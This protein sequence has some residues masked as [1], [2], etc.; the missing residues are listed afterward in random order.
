MR[1]LLTSLAACFVALL[2]AAPFDAA[3]AQQPP[4]LVGG[5]TAQRSGPG[6]FFDF[7]FGPRPVRPP[8]QQQQ[9]RNK[10]ARPRV[11]QPSEPPV[12][13]AE[14]TP[15]DEKARKIM[16]VGDFVAG[17]LAWGL[18]QTFADEP[19]IAVL[20][21]SNNASGLVRDDYYDW[22]KKLPAILNEQK[23]DVVIVVIG[24]NDRQ[25]LRS[26]KDR[27]AVHSDGWEKAYVNRITGLADTLK[28]FGRPFFWV[29]APPMGASS[30][31]RDMDYFN[32]LYKAA[33]TAAGGHYVDIW[34]GFTDDNGNY[35]SSG[36]DV[37]GQLR[38]LRN[39][40]GINFTRA[41]RLK[42]AFYVEREIRKQTGIGA[43]AVDLFASASQTT[44]I[45]IGP[46]G[47]K[48]LVG[49]VISL[50]DPLPGAS[51]TLVGGADSPDA[52]MAADTPQYKLIVEGAVQPPLPGR[53]DDFTWP[54]SRRASLTTVPTPASV[55][56]R[57]GPTPVPAVRPATS[58]N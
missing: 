35:T 2:L 44:Q 16:V 37:D 41:G 24:A 36:P 58:A 20:D 6:G 29:S 42:L 4:G 10:P 21:Q 49:P 43:G 56:A 52:T 18:D 47:V 57:T 8:A 22:N 31:S 53:A 7:L 32:G 14:V 46:D 38:A 39:S 40:D 33:V 28:V 25:Q 5:Q 13:V 26:G 30:A 15:K 17:G 27:L 12:A 48:R 51:R 19:K 50:S 34:N 9:Q 54:P 55:T 3:L 23:P 45:E 1:R 11:S